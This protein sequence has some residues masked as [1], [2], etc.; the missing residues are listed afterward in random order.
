MRRGILLGCLLGLLL[1]GL[2]G[3]GKEDKPS[4]PSGPRTPRLPKPAG[5]DK[6][7]Q[8]QKP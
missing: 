1:A 8:G 6:K 2:A 4:G 5:V 7:D 3:C